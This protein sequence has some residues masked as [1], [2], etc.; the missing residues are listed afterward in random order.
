M[1]TNRETHATD[2]EQP[3]ITQ[4]ENYE[5]AGVS[6]VLLFRSHSNLLRAQ[7]W[8]VAILSERPYVIVIGANMDIKH[9]PDSSLVAGDS[10]LVVTHVLWWC[11]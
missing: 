8:A 7:F 5:R 3:S 10:T 1:L 9:R 2:K 11:G 6:H 4:K